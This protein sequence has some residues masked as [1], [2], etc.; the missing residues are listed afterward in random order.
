MNARELLDY[1]KSKN[2]A[3]SANN[4]E[5]VVRAA[6]GTLDAEL[7]AL[8][9][10]NKPTLLE[11]LRRNTG[12]DTGQNTI[13][14]AVPFRITPDL[15]PLVKLTQ[16][17]I[18]L[19]V[20]KVPQG[21]ANIQDIY[22]LASLQEGIL[23]HHL[24]E[25]EG[26]PYL[27]RYLLAFDNRQRLDAF[28]GA[29]QVVINRHD[30]LRT[31]IHWQDLAQPVQVVHR[32]ATLPVTEFDV[33]HGED[34]LALLQERTDPRHLRLDLTR[35][36]LLS[37]QVC[38][39]R[40]T[41]KW[42]LSL[43]NHHIITDH[44]GLEIVVAETQL[45]LQ[46]LASRLAKPVPYRNFIAQTLAADASV[47]EAYFT[48]LLG[49]VTEPTA[50]FGLSDVHGSSGQVRQCKLA[51]S[52]ELAQNIRDC[53]RGQ[54]VTASVLFHL[55][56]A[57]VLAICS[58]R[59]D[60]VFGTVLSGRLQG[61]DDNAQV[62]GM[63]INTLPMRIKLAGCSVAE[64][65][66][67]MQRQIIDLLAHE[68]ASL[69]LAQRC[70][71]VPAGTPLFSAIF[72]YRHSHGEAES[73]S[74]AIAEGI[75]VLDSEERTN[76]PLMVS[77]DDL[78]RG[79][80]L[81]AQCTGG[82]DPS[83]IAAYV[84]QAIEALVKALRHSP[85]QAL[86]AL[87]ILPPVERRQ[88][89]TG[90]NDTA[91]PYPQD[92]LIHQLFEAQVART[93]DAIALSFEDEH[94]S[95]TELNARANRLAHHLRALGVVPD[96]RVAVCLERSIA[97]VVGLFA[98][99]K[100]GGAYVPLDPSYPQERLAYML[101][102]SAPATILAHGATKALLQRLD[103]AVSV[104]DLDADGD[105]WSALDATNPEPQAVGLTS[106]H[107]AY[108]IY[109]SGSTGQPKGVMNE[110]R[111]VVNRLL[112]GQD[113]YRLGADD[114]LLQK[115]PFS[116]DVSVPEFFWP[117]GC[118]ARLVLARPLGHQD[119]EYLCDVMCREGVTTVHFV[120]AML[121]LFLAHQNLGR[122]TRLRQV[123]CSGEALPAA[124]VERFHAVSK[125]VAL[126]NLYGPTE[127]AVE[128]TAWHYEPGALLKTVPIGKPV[129][130]TQAYVLDR[131]L[132]PVPVGVAG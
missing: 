78:G 124:L 128:V 69:T 51:L 98:V 15:L 6:Q 76:Y 31:A 23:F 34:A 114:V 53:A 73:G 72:N 113:A 52:E 97:M 101:S 14:T 38:L 105:C 3:V 92:I 60:V 125:N 106:R 28:L 44:A 71:S 7:V 88:V 35:A 107:L 94:L 129:P 116:F 41:G 18:D 83:R 4:S 22:P 84:G 103:Y 95:Y 67:D 112:W 29:L 48:A 91:L 100:A 66:A 109:T 104:I 82:M 127:A 26:D 123:F 58:S 17:E 85:Q 16:E 81:K 65:T 54:G 126:H 20:Q 62:L 120:P 27:L 64:A 102:D 74:V 77:V 87:D 118:G 89:L 96:A 5:L 49:D 110:H 30:V 70:S 130:N 12:H 80:S 115:T 131:H 33:P 1:L 59:D 10:E 61:S 122:C 32:K 57:Q 40:P 13:N 86:A 43:L 108:V 47:Y 37:V 19:I 63:F 132:Q 39:D 24:L 56:W 42:L 111:S 119:P 93:P 11:E 75:S 79:F 36:P 2:V 9:K 25:H 121:Q 99:L 90:F 55:A 68:Q 21:A 46:G 45:L 8:L 117:L 50:P